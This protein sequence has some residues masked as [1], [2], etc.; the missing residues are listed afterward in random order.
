MRAFI[1]GAV[2]LLSGCDGGLL[3]PSGPAPKVYTLSAPATVETSAQKVNW[4]LLIDSPDAILDLDAAR[5]AI[6]PDPNRIDYYANV[7]WADRP[8]AMLQELLLQAFDK[9]GRIAAVQRQSGGLKAD[10]VLATDLQNFEVDTGPG[11]ANVHIRITARLIRA[12][13]RTIVASRVF[14]SNTPVSGD[15]EGGIAAFDAALQTLLPQIVD[16]TLVQGSRNT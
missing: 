1:L 13:D 5:I 15:F 10:F 7:T 12:R 2:L 8:P 9:S 11:A 4:Q 6:R 3:A 16:W 14:E